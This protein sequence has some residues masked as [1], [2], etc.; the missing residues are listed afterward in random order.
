[1]TS[2]KLK[3]G[4]AVPEPVVRTVTLLLEELDPVLLCEAVTKARN[5]GYRLFGNAGSRLAEMGLVDESF[6]MHDL[7]RQII[8]AAAVGDG[9]EIELVSPLAAQES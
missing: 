6:H 9:L 8:E 5:K 1:M 3:T 4:P 7:T 2:L